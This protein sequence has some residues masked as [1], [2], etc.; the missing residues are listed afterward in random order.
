M[1]IFLDTADTELIAQHFSTGMV[2]GVTTNPSLIAKSGRFP[3]VVYRELVDLGVPD[4]SM[5]VIGD[6]E[7][8]IDEGIQL[9]GEFGGVAT[10]KVPCTREGLKACRHLADMGIDVN[11]T[12]IFSVAQAVLAA[13]AKAKYVSPFIGR[14]DDQQFDG[15]DLVKDIFKVYVKSNMYRRPH[16]LAASI[17]TVRDAVKSWEN[18]A[19]I[20][21][22]PPAIL[23]KMYDHVLTDKGLAIFDNDARSYQQ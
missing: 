11:V 4:I 2:D 3:V 15:L 1:K 9:Y 14:I 20:V 22:M 17:R 10:I 8:M 7:Q 23:D 21:T 12:L 19:D 13:K 6:S 18:G 16:I 5:E